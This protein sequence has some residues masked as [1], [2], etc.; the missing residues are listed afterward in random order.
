M[1]IV[2]ANQG[3]SSFKVQIMSL[4]KFCMTSL[5]CSKFLH[6]SSKCTYEQFVFSNLWFEMTPSWIPGGPSDCYQTALPDGFEVQA[7]HVTTILVGEGTTDQNW[8]TNRF[9]Q[10]YCKCFNK[11]Y[12][13]FKMISKIGP[14]LFPPPN[15]NEIFHLF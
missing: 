3:P 13:F 4:Q 11:A 6:V 5:F 2:R 15:L 10:S 7:S 9:F 8:K 1:K 12:I 14:M